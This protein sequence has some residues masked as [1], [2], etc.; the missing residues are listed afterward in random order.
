MSDAS[1]EPLGSVV[2]EATA[3]L[4]R[5]KSGSATKA[6]EEAW[7][8]WHA[9]S[10]ERQTAWRRL[11]EIEQDFDQIAPTERR[12]ARAALERT[13]AR[14]GRRNTLKALAW[15]AIGGGMALAG[16]Q[17][18]AARRFRADHA[19]GVGET[20][21]IV[22][23]D[24][25]E[26]RLN[27]DTL[28]DTDQ[29][30]SG[31]RI[32]LLR[33]EIHVA[34]NA[35]GLRD[36]LTVV[37]S[38]ASFAPTGTRFLLRHLGDTTRLAVIEGEVRVMPRGR[39]AEPA[40]SARKGEA[41]RITPSDATSDPLFEQM[42]PAAWLEGL[43]VFKRMH[44]GDVLDELARYRTGLLYATPEVAGLLVSGVY[45]LD[46]VD[47]ALRAIEASLPVRIRRFTP[48]VIVVDAL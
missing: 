22:I 6:D 2:D 37:T 20:T 28:L 44:L 35:G 12:A 38:H 15:V 42:D 36:G 25:A 45:R 39:G 3:W 19:T 41:L 5:F 23:P 16:M 18:P 9:S 31:R 14:Q 7:K 34:T 4:V 46:A 1:D 29:S 40:F 47:D 10:P 27:T 17:T 13:F 43:L 24:G 21:R 8:R 33:G 48:Y 32:D 26:V 30:P 11:R